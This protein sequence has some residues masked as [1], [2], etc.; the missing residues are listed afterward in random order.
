MTIYGEDFT[1]SIVIRTDAEII[2]ALRAYTTVVDAA[3]YLGIAASTIYERR[4]RSP[5]VALAICQQRMGMFGKAEGALE[6]LIDAGDFRA[7]NLVMRTMGEE[8]RLV[9]RV[10]HHEITDEAL[11]RAI[12]KE[13]ERLG[14]E[15]S[16]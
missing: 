2:G 9:E 3:K 6:K 14:Q 11:D 15:E 8:L 16:Q 10:E 1:M 7:I 4:K 13:R 5:D 12:A